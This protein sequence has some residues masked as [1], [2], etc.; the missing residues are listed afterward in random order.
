MQ[1]HANENLNENWMKTDEKKR[2]HIKCIKKNNI[3]I[4]I[5]KM[6]HTN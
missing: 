4:H 6:A 2:T 1:H 5:L 3:S